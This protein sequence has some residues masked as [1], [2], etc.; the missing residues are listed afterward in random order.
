MKICGMREPENVMAVAKLLPDFMGFIFYKESPRYVG[1]DFYVPE[2]FPSTI[3]K[4]GV[5]VNEDPD[6]IL[7][8][9]IRHRL[10]FI[11][12]HGDE[13]PDYC[14]SLKKGSV[15]LIKAFRVDDDFDFSTTTAFVHVCDLFLFDAKGKYFGGNARTFDWQLLSKY[16]GATPF[17]LSGG[18]TEK[19]ISAVKSIRHI[20]L[21]G[22]D[23]NSGIELAPGKKDLKRIDQILTELKA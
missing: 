21:E 14:S 1:K 19:N 13:S 16:M 10:D 4:V 9:V 7:A 8:Y 5:F 23:L 12:L 3:K 15:S 18:L 20:K 2:S 22:V 17:L 11:Q 6:V